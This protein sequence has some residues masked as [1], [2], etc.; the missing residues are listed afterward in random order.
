MPKSTPKRIDFNEALSLGER[1]FQDGKFKQAA[2]LRVN[3]H[4]GLRIGDFQNNVTWA[5]ILYRKNFS[6]IPEKTRKKKKVCTRPI[7]S[8]VREFV[9]KCYIGSGSPQEIEPIWINSHKTKPASQ[10]SINRVMKTWIAL[11]DIRDTG[12]DSIAAK[13]FSTH[14]IRKTAAWKVYEATEYNIEA[15]R[16]FLLHDSIEVTKRYLG[17]EEKELMNMLQSIY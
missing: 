1:L 10:E 17:V 2:Y 12:G 8:E 14:S 16:R 3:L 13:H 15:A 7:L 5:S 11:Y 4:F 6:C 9:E